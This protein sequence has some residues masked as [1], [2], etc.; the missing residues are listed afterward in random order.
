[1]N[2]GEIR[3]LCLYWLDDLQGAYFTPTQMNVFINNAQREV[4]K[5]LIQAF[6]DYYLRVVQTVT[7]ANQADYQLPQD[8]MKLRRLEIVLSGTGVNENATQLDSI[9]LN[10]KNFIQPGNGTPQNYILKAD[11]FSILP[12][13]S[14][15]N[16]ILRLFYT[17]RVEDMTQDSDTPDIPQDYHEYIAVLAALDGFVK[18]DR[19]PSNLLDKREAY[20]RLMKQTA[21]DRKTDRSRQ[22]VMRDTDFIGFLW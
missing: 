6:E 7:V 16:Q 3:S 19:A 14:T 17:Y 2:R 13:P 21:E 20:L 11:R 5:Q 15:P 4:Q 9:T 8:F 10:Q 12:I 22:V 18:D 1:M